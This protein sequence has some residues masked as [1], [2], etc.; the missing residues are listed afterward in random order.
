MDVVHVVLYVDWEVLP[1]LS[2]GNN[3][4]ATHATII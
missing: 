4:I 1:G 2:K 3:E